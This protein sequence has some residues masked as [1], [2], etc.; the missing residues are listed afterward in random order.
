MR[1]STRVE[2]AR[3]GFRFISPDYSGSGDCP[4]HESGFCLLP[5]QGQSLREVLWQS[6]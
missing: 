3:V 2:S 1:R 4:D 5:R 6:V